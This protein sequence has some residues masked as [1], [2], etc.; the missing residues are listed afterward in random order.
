MKTAV[1]VLIDGVPIKV[2]FLTLC[3]PVFVVV[4]VSDR[5]KGT[6]GTAPGVI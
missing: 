2:G 1:S 4:S 3:A 6:T 5:R